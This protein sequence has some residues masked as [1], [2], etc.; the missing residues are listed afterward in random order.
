MSDFKDFL[1]KVL[2]PVRDDE[3]PKGAPSAS[4]TLLFLKFED[5][6]AQD[7]RDILPQC[8]LQRRYAAVMNHLVADA[9][10]RS[11]LAALTDVVT[12]TLAEIAFH[13]GSCGTG[14]IVRK[15]GAHLESLGAVEQARLKPETL[16]Y[17]AHEAGKIGGAPG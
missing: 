9:A 6:E 17:R 4:L 8:E 1:D 12:R 3:S 16:A 7:P 13:F 2:A 11:A 10:K 14:E 5:P 15:L